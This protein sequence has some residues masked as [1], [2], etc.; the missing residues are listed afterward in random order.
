ML[1][2]DEAILFVNDERIDNVQTISDL[3]Q[4]QILY[5]GKMARITKTVNINSEKNANIKRSKSNAGV[6]KATNMRTDIEHA[7]QQG[8]KISHSTI[9]AFSRNL[10]EIFKT[11]SS[12][13]FEYVVTN[14]IS[15]ILFTNN[16]VGK[17]LRGVISTK[18]SANFCHNRTKC[19]P[20]GMNKVSEQIKLQLLHRIRVIQVKFSVKMVFSHISPSNGQIC[21]YS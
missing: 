9:S 14:L 12:Q 8:Q 2:F 16:R 15:V 11:V 5:L 6:I 3:I 1:P 21:C 19:V 18:F 13:A 17:E 10:E 20:F 4:F 7:E